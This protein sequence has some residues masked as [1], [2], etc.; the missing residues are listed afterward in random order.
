M[1]TVLETSD[2]G[3]V[4]LTLNRPER[5]NALSPEMVDLFIAK[6]ERL[7][8]ADDAACVVVRG[9]GRAFCAGGDVKRMAGTSERGYEERLA[10]LRHVHR[11]PKLLHDFPKPTIAVVNGAAVGAGLNL[12][13]ACDLRFM[14]QSA[15]LAAAFVRVGLASD[16]GGSWFLTRLVGPAKARD[17]LLLGEQLDSAAALRA[18]LVNSVH[19]DSVLDEAANALARR[20]ADGPAIALRL[21]KKELLAAENG[22]LDELLELEAVNQARAGTTEDHREAA[23]AF[24]ER[25]APLFRGR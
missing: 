10:S 1:D 16:Y 15:K 4:T 18:G 25:R 20:L 17:M 13:L 22:T 19:E 23:L 7:A 11:L 6:L 24:V 12:A 5:L 21:L 14:S 3:V 2:R 9:A 8:D